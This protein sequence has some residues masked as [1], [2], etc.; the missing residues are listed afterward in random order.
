[1]VGRLLKPLPENGLYGVGPFLTM[2]QTDAVKAI[3]DCLMGDRDSYPG[4]Y[5]SRLIDEGYLDAKEVEEAAVCW[6]SSDL[7]KEK[8]GWHG[9][10]E[11]IALP[12]KIEPRFEKVSS[13][14]AANFDKFY[15]LAKEKGI[16]YLFLVATAMAESLDYRMWKRI[17]TIF[18]QEHWTSISLFDV[19]YIGSPWA[20]AMDRERCLQCIAKWTR[21]MQRSGDY[22][23]TTTKTLIHMLRGHLGYTF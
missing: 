13:Y 22:E 18:M 23:E 2:W 17:N 12:R 20:K 4:Q 7:I 16:D 9:F 8:Y 1:M 10:H 19:L 6:L 11:I 5:I 3:G 21:R 15:P 14:L